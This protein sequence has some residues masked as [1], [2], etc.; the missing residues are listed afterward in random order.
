MGRKSLAN[1]RREQILNAFA[2]CLDKY[3]FEG[4]SLERIAQ[5]AGV[6]RSIIRHY[7]GNRDDL[8]T[9]AVDHIISDY[10]EKLENAFENLSQT[11][12]ISELLNYLFANDNDNIVSYHDNILH[13]LWSTHER[14]P[15]T[16]E[17]LHNLYS[18]F[19]SLVFDLLTRVYPQSDEDQRHS[20]ALTIMC[21]M[22]STW[23]FISI[24]FPKTRLE[25][26][27]QV[28]EQLITE[29]DN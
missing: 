6:Q 5:Q 25:T 19:E 12:L 14:N 27:R 15:H 11:E 8:I 20:T 21:L 28:A 24:G 7:I 2:I 18:A 4:S 1:E 13:A 3:G 10:K 17:L 22:D 26:A 29:L 16:R 23:S 9:A